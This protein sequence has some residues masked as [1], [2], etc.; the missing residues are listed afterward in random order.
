MIVS[1]ILIKLT[2]KG[3]VIFAQER[4]GLHNKPF[5]MYKFRTMIEQTE[6]EEAQGWTR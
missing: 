2:S 1:A 3:P 5:Q 6:A 4:V